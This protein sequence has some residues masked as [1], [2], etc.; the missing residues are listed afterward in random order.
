[1]LVDHPERREDP[2]PKPAAT[3][4]AMN[5]EA[6]SAATPGV[7]G[8]PAQMSRDELARVAGERLRDARRRRGMSLAQLAAATG[9]S[10]SFLSRVERGLSAA[11][12]ESLLVWTRALDM[13]VAALFEPGLERFHEPSQAPAFSMTGVADYLLTERDETRFEVFEEHLEPGGAP[14]Q[15]FWSVDADYAFVYVIRGALRMEFG[16]G[17]RHIE[18]GP[19]DLHVY[20]PREPHRWTNVSPERTML[21][22]FESPAR[23]F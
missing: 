22:I 21:L 8:L 3:T 13:T 11:S 17:E 18:L 4:D 16:H 19:G 6:D 10:R 5:R 2:G 12:V 23:R 15:R 9:L 1:V 14:D 7:P 20:Q